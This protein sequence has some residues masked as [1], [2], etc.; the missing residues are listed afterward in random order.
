MQNLSVPS[1]GQTSKHSEK[2]KPGI[3]GVH[4]AFKSKEIRKPLGVKRIQYMIEQRDRKNRKREERRK[5]RNKDQAAEKW[6]EADRMRV[7]HESAITSRN[8]S[9]AWT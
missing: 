2:A 7:A 9:L 1:R 4:P 3:L 8:T 6:M 5:Q